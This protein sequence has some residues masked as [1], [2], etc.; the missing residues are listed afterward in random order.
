MSA[1]S[2]EVDEAREA[3]LHVEDFVDRK[4]RSAWRDYKDF[5][6]R[7]SVL[8]VAV[9]L[10]IA[11]AF[12]T[13]VKSLVSDILL[14]PMSLLPFMQRNLPDK[15]VVLRSGPEGP[16]YLTVDQAAEDGAVT[17]AYGRFLDH[18]IDFLAV[19]WVLF[20]FAQIYSRFAPETIIKH[21]VKCKYCRKWISEKALRCFNC[22]SWTD[23]R[24]DVVQNR[25]DL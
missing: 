15:F 11:S 18:T 4:A 22:S 7:D 12:T 16:H 21:Q 20:I 19:G 2:R 25:S 24:E 5:I 8:E 3:L 17:L 13:L 1:L 10:I 6:G 23:G 9:G 14:P